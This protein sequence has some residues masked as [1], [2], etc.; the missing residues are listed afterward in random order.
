MNFFQKIFY[1]V[2]KYNFSVP[3]SRDDFYSE[4]EKQEFKVK[5][6][7]DSFDFFKK[8]SVISALFVRNSL[9]FVGKGSVTRSTESKTELSVNFRMNA[10]GLFFVILWTAIMLVM[11]GPEIID[12]I[13]FYSSDDAVFI[14]MPF[15][16]IFMYITG[17]A[18]G[19]T[20]VTKFIEFVKSLGGSQIEEVTE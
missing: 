12:A 2:Q 4:L 10:F 5:T 15:I 20:L 8:R 3:L 6:E 1:P 14:L 9:Y 19:Q 7:G 17:N 16:G 18:I 13:R 11:F